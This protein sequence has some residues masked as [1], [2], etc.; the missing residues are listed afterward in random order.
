MIYPKCILNKKVIYFTLLPIFFYFGQKLLKDREIF[1]KLETNSERQEK[2]QNFCENRKWLKKRKLSQYST[3]YLIL[4]TGSKTGNEL[5]C[6]N[7]K[8]GSTSL[9]TLLYMKFTNRTIP[10]NMTS[11]KKVT[12]E[13][14]I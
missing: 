5:F 8:T 11:G 13:S 14:D 4:A 9:K 3:I 12:F 1:E 2:L 10:E 6:L 7:P